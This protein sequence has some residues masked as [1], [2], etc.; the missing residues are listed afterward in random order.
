MCVCVLQ[1]GGEGGERRGKGLCDGV[2]QLECK[3]RE[4]CERVCV[5]VLERF[6]CL[7]D[8]P[9]MH[10]GWQHSHNKLVVKTSLRAVTKLVFKFTS[11]KF[12]KKTRGSVNHNYVLAQYCCDRDVIQWKGPREKRRDN[13]FP[14]H[15]NYD[16]W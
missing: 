14:T 4:V 9:A 16:E 1:W 2:P 13:R 10:G 11:F 5:C 12:N 15:L 3:D 6:V 8:F 7:K